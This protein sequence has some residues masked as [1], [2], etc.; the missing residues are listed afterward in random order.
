[1][2]SVSVLRAMR[3]LGGKKLSQLPLKMTLLLLL[4]LAPARGDV[5]ADLVDAL[6]AALALGHGPGIDP[7]TAFPPLAA[8]LLRPLQ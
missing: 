8:L 1:M 4:S 6:L 2:K 3:Y 5:V 7:R